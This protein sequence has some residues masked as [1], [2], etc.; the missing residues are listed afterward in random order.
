MKVESTGSETEEAVSVEI[1]DDQYEALSKVL[2]EHVS[3]SA[4]QKR[5][6]QLDIS[7]DAKQ[8]VSGIM[9]I[10][11]RVGDTLLKIGQK[12][13]ELV[14]VILKSYPNTTFGLVLGMLVGF[15]VSSIPFLGGIL[16]SFL[17]PLAL[18]F[19]LAKGFMEDMSNKSLESKIN[20][21]VSMFEPLKGQA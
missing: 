3:R 16:G 8:I 19:G 13:I 20:E 18:A 17:I 12:I 7:A 2:G 15:L 9:K 21:A 10:T 5:I 14:L 11:I 6:D 4:I 1:S